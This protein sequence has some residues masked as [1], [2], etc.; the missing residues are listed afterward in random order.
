M[1]FIDNKSTGNAKHLFPCYIDNEYLEHKTNFLNKSLTIIKN[2]RKLLK[3]EYIKT[4][5]EESTT[6]VP[7]FEWNQLKTT[8]NNLDKLLK[9]VTDKLDK[10]IRKDK[11]K[12][13]LDSIIKVLTPT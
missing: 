8:E 13:S 1:G 12:E 7:S 9:N 11:F 10:D 4:I 5:N 6:Y 3:P 2:K